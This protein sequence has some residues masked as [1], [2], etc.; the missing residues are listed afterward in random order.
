MGLGSAAH[1]PVRDSF[2]HPQSKLF[3]ACWVPVQEICSFVWLPAQVSI[4]GARAR[5][6]LRM[7]NFPSCWGEVGINAPTV[8]ASRCFRAPCGG[9]NPPTEVLLAVHV[10]E[11]LHHI[12]AHHT[13]LPLS[14]FVPVLSH[15]QHRINQTWSQ[16]LSLPLSTAYKHTLPCPAGP[17][18]LS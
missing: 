13:I 9:R 18:R 12:L 5:D 7:N 2:S 8:V 15:D 3:I 4:L 16:C 6:A 10:C 11:F 14:S 1:A 17:H